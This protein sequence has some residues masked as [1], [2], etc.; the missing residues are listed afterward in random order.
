MRKMGSILKRIYREE[1]ATEY[2]INWGNSNKDVDPVLKRRV[3][4][5][6]RDFKEIALISGIGGARTRSGQA[7]AYHGYR[8]HRSNLAARPG[9]SWHEYSMAIDT[10]SRWLQKLTNAQLKPYGLCKPV[11]GENWHIQ[12][13]ESMIATKGES[14]QSRQIRLYN[15]CHDA[16]YASSFKSF[17]CP[18]C[19]KFIDKDGNVHD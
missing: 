9:T 3:A 14:K 2:Y 7:Q 18:I 4:A 10:S 5:V 16:P 12:P 15:G 19:K 11:K 1:E 6:A 13:L 8:C 17:A